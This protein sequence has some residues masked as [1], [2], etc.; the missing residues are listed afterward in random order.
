M[1][2]RRRTGRSAQRRRLPS[3]AKKLTRKLERSLPIGDAEKLGRM[4]ARTLKRLDGAAPRRFLE[5]AHTV[6]ECANPE[7]NNVVYSTYNV[8]IQ[9]KGALI[10]TMLTARIANTVQYKQR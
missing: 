2:A 9:R 6:V 3:A 7:T 5:V 1:G 10:F 8:V 4:Q